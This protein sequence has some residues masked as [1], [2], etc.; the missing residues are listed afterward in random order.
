MCVKILSVPIIIIVDKQL[1]IFIFYCLKG[2]IINLDLPQ[3]FFWISLVFSPLIC[4]MCVQMFSL[5][6]IYTEFTF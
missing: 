5:L 2:E 3:K 6:Y 4:F 1:W